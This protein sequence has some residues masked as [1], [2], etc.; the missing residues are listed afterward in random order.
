MSEAGDKDIEL[1]LSLLDSLD[2]GEIPDMATEDEENQTIKDTLSVQERISTQVVRASKVLESGRKIRV[3]EQQLTATQVYEPDQAKPQI[4]SSIESPMPA[5]SSNILLLGGIGIIL[6]GLAGGLYGYVDQQSSGA[7]ALT[8]EAEPLRLAPRSVPVPTKS[9]EVSPEAK[10]AESSSP[11]KVEKSR[12]NP[13]NKKITT[14]AARGKVE[15]SSAGNE[16]ANIRALGNLVP[17]PNKPVPAN[18]EVPVLPPLPKIKKS[19]DP[20]SKNSELA[21]MG[22]L[23]L[24]GPAGTKIQIDMAKIGQLPLP[25][26]VLPAGRHSVWAELKGHET[27]ML[28]VQVKASESR[29]VKVVMKPIP[30]ATLSEP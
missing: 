29:T 3:L 24:L 20:K 25:E 13:R 2:Q 6:I 30:K 21:K 28:D 15:K 9:V 16:D 26:L 17:Q 7:S 19:S 22:R 10:Q 14:R 23:I 4:E 18:A 1:D 27:R 12:T 8:L 5:K 11:S